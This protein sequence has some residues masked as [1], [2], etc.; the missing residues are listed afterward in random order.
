[1][2]ALFDLLDLAKRRRAVKSARVNSSLIS[3]RAFS[4]DWRS[5][6]RRDH[7]HGGTRTPPYPDPPSDRADWSHPDRP[8]QK[9]PPT[10]PP[11][12]PRPHPPHARKED[13]L[14]RYC[15]S[16]TS[17]RHALEAQRSLRAKRRPQSAGSTERATQMSKSLQASGQ[18]S[19]RPLAEANRVVRVGTRELALA[20][21][22][23]PLVSAPLRLA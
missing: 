5:R 2:R 23:E 22:P 19:S 6:W 14:R 1:M 4:A 3:L 16:Q 15:P 8:D 13:A 21:P 18:A 10:S 11:L 7:E 12:A 9:S 20:P 17:N